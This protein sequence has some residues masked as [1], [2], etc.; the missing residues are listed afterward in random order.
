MFVVAIAAGAATTACS[1]SEPSQVT[2]GRSASP[3]TTAEAPGAS[4]A[5]TVSAFDVEGAANPA[6]VERVKAGVVT[7]L[8]R[9]LQAG[10]L[11]P[12]RSGGPAGELGPLFS[13][14]AA[15]HL[16]SSSDRNAF[17]DEGLPPAWRIEARA[18]SLHLTGLADQAG[19]V[20]LVAARMDLKL[21]AGAQG[22]TVTIARGADLLLVADGDEWK[23]DA[24]WVRVTRD[25]PDLSSTM[26]A[27]G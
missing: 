3:P 14:R 10:V 2:I 20:V 22:T 12:L 8:T 19:Q 6:S 13:A 17:V 15:E 16:A 7:T 23:I 18:S 21:L 11:T 1:R 25:T 9:Y 26:V 4:V 5:F 27:A 24:Y